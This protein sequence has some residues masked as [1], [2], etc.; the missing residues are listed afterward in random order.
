M[1]RPAQ[2]ASPSPPARGAAVSGALAASVA[3]GD[4]VYLVARR[5]AIAIRDVIDINHLSPPYQLRRGQKLVI[6]SVRIH[7]VASGD[8]LYSVSRRYETDMYTVASINQIE[9]PFTIHIGRDLRLPDRRASRRETAAVGSAQAPEVQATEPPATQ[10]T[11]QKPVSRTTR[12]VWPL[13][14]T[15]ISG[16]GPKPGGLHNDGINIAA[17]AGAAVVAADGGVVAYAGNELRGFGNL[18]LL[19]HAGGWTTA[20]AHNEKLLVKRGQRV[21]RGHV[22]AR[23]G[24]SGRVGR[25]QLHFELR[26]GSDAIDPLGFLTPS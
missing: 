19:R 11:K 22:I 26:K 16:F 14:G 15:V 25:P 10:N 24:T 5:Y 12:F 7:R 8:T 4:T 13:R 18:L 9:A 6:P 21:A 1:R 20:Y 2:L 17:S 3:E 23:A